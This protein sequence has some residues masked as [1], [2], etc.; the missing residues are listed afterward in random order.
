[1]TG[2]ANLTR[3]V[4]PRDLFEYGHSLLREIGS[5]G[6]EGLILWAG[7]VNED[8]F[9]VEAV[10]QPAQRCVRAHEGLCVL[11][12]GPELH[13]IGVW[14]YQRR[15]RLIAQLHSHPAEAYHSATDDAIPIVATEGG[16][17]LVVPDFARGNARLDSY[18]TYRLDGAGRW[19]ELSGA[20]VRRLIAI[21]ESS[22][23]RFPALD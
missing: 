5:D 19:R 7:T 14:L 2:F 15:L 12:D 4:V 10:L 1:M 3:V 20:M 8:L 18:A 23:D 6:A 11:V 22:S 9:R 13:R 16:L 21:V 17:S